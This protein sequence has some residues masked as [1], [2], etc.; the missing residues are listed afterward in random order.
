MISGLLFRILQIK[1]VKNELN[2]F[3]ISKTK[4]LLLKALELYLNAS[5]K[6]HS[7]CGSGFWHKNLSTEFIK[8]Y[9][10][11]KYIILNLRIFKYN[12]EKRY[13]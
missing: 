5:L 3:F 13:L 2:K 10:E 8:I 6:S 9:S 11:R 4:Q 12:S 7:A 1:I